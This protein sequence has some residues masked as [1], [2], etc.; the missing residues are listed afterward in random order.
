V[1]ED[2]L[3]VKDDMVVGLDYTLR[4]EDGAVVDSS[5]DRE[6]LKY[7][8]GQGQIIPGLEQELY[9]MAVGDEKSVAVEPAQGYGEKDPSA[10]QVVP[11]EAFPPDLEPAPGMRLQMRDEQGRVFE[12]FVVEVRSDDVVL[13]FNH[14]LAGQT[15]HFDVKI[16]SLRRASEEE[17]AHGH[18]HEGG[19]AH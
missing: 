2:K 8:Q 19:H 14:P 17:L 5:E 11:N 15:L 10:V 1:T 13:D 12:A 7:L 18:A 3:V 6:P 9:G 4:L 16:D